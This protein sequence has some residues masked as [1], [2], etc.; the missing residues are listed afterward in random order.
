MNL[1]Y[2]FVLYINLTGLF[3]SE[4]MIINKITNEKYHMR[5]KYPITVLNLL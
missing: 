1:Y 4:K 2:S 5:Y 3:Y